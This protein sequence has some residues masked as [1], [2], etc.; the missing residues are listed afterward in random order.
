MRFYMSV[1]R[2][3]LK[4]IQSI[5]DIFFTSIFLYAGEGSD[6]SYSSSPFSS[7]FDLLKL[8]VDI[9]KGI[10]IIQVLILWSML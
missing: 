4:V 8:A 2:C 9:F 6:D 5:T 1:E 3:I 10:V 7:G